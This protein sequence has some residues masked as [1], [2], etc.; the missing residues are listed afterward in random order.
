MK[1]SE[2]EVHKCESSVVLN[3]FLGAI[4]LMLCVPGKCLNRIL[5]NPELPLLSLSSE[6]SGIFALSFPELSVAPGV[7]P[8]GVY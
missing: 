8:E 2:S 1:V 7:F 4:L 3:L 6:A 5:K